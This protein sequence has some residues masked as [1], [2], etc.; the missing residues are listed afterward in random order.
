MIEK[1]VHQLR[2]RTHKV[3]ANKLRNLRL[4]RALTQAELATKAGYSERLIRK[5]E[6]GGRLNLAT[7]QDLATVLSTEQ[8]MVDP[9]DLV[10]SNVA[11]ATRFVEAYDQ[12]GPRMIEHCSDIL[13]D[14]F[15][16][17]CRGDKVSRLSGK[18]KGRDGF[19]AWLNQFFGMVDRPQKEK[20]EVRYLEG[21]DAVT[22]HFCDT[23]LVA[24]KQES[25]WVN[26]HFTFKSGL[27][28]GVVDEY[29][30]LLVLEFE[31]RVAECRN[32]PNTLIQDDSAAYW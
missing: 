29:D 4:H 8:E 12:F 27:I 22:A 17:V 5:A 2:R 20:L 3:C 7:L 28:A 18:W 16:F 32:D 15:S 30:T 10:V 21:L 13:A 23:F 9:M 14:D 26:W 11:S 1:S 24:G 31:K 25:M 19:Q 6:A